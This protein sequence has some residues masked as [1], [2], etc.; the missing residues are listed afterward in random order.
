MERKVTVFLAVVSFL[1]VFKSACSRLTWSPT[2]SLASLSSILTD[3][4][5]CRTLPS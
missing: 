2:H 1:A 4:Q 5:S 3:V